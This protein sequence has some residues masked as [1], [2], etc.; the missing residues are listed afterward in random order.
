MNALTEALD[1]W[2][3]LYRRENPHTSKEAAASIEGARTR[4]QGEVINYALLRAAEGFTDE[5]LSRWFCCNGSTYRTRRAELTA[6][7]IIIPTGRRS[8]L[9][10]GRNAVVWVHKR[11]QQGE[12]M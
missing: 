6:Q 9:K 1:S 8:R 12:V 10:S 11:F 2:R 5:D 4:I 3:G 7:G